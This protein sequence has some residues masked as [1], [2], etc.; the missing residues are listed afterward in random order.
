MKLF[1]ILDGKTKRQWTKCSRLAV[2]TGF[3]ATGLM[4]HGCAS[5]GGANVAENPPAETVQTQSGE[6]S[7]ESAGKS[8]G[9]DASAEQEAKP[10][11]A[12][13][14]PQVEVATVGTEK[15][16]LVFEWPAETRSG[17]EIEVRPRVEGTLQASNFKEGNEVQKGQV[18]FTIEDSP[19]RADVAAA[20]AQVARAEADLEYAE[21]QVNLRRAEANL[22][23]AKT[24]LNRSQQDVDRYKPLAAS[25]T[26]AQQILDNAIALRDTN[27]AK[28]LA[29]QAT[30][31]T[32]KAS[33]V[34]QIKVCKAN[35][36][37]AKAALATAKLNLSYCTIYSPIH[38]VIGKI[39]VYPGNLVGQAGDTRPLVKISSLDPMYVDFSMTEE[40]YYITT[41][42]RGRE[43][44]VAKYQFVL[45]NGV[46]CPQL[47]T[48][49]MID[50]TMDA[51]TSTIGVRVRFPNPKQ[52]LREGQFGRLR[53]TSNHDEEVVVVPK[54]AVQINQTEYSVY[55]LD[56][57][58]K[59]A[60]RNITVGKELDE[61]F[62]VNT[63]LKAGETIVLDGLNKVKVGERCVPIN[64]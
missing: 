14:L 50:R 17:E 28:V 24:E 13:I 33:D 19:Y 27:K 20:E 4:L 34:S 6:G 21:N 39:D 51:G 52:I 18:L 58:N 56:E 40:E 62:V 54:R 47:G 57:D 11:T 26:I 45:S 7:G 61:Q 37:A 5:N 38:G 49:Y 59:V 3:V 55:V 30:V 29:E 35:L 22:A 31:E 46:V 23:S 10:K 48:F 9:E 25:G 1:H 32:T 63:G 60:L 53:L 64:K 44:D 36:A 15:H 41:K 2:A 43:N 42:F 8:A 12:G 16:K